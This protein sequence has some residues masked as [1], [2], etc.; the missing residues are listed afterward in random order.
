[1]LAQ[2]KFARGITWVVSVGILGT[3]GL[4]TGCGPIIFADGSPLAVVGDPP[5]P[6][7]EPEPEPPAKKR[8]TVTADHI[9]IS[10]KIQFDF[11]KATIKAESHGL[12]DEIVQVFK[13]NPHIRE[14]EVI[15]HTDSDGSD[16]Y[17]KKLSDKRAAAV[18]QYLVDHGIAEGTLL[19]KGMG[20][21][22]PIASNETDEGKATNRRVEFKISKQDKV[23]KTYEVDSKTGER[24]E[25]DSKVV[26]S[27]KP[28]T[29][30][31]KKAEEKKEGD[32]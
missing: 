22:Q 32:R 17:N 23:E 24:R 25:V 15:G 11:N 26:G 19:S 16:R 29:A 1:M 4:V 10:E 27:P 9:V 20:E 5:P 3:M 30:G 8:V 18:R 31:D 13:E 28:E 21:E 6:P 7:P 14:V 12:L 2:R